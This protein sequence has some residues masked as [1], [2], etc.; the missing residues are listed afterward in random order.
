MKHGQKLQVVTFLYLVI[1]LNLVAAK[2]GCSFDVEK[3]KPTSA[4]EK[5]SKR[6]VIERHSITFENDWAVKIDSKI[7]GGTELTLWTQ[8]EKLK[9][10]AVLKNALLTFDDENDLFVCDVKKEKPFINISG[11]E[12]IF[13]V[14]NGKN[15]IFI[16]DKKGN[17]DELKIKFI[18]EMPEKEHAEEK[19]PCML[20]GLSCKWFQGKYVLWN[21]A[22]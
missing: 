21:Y 16:K 7:I 5:P 2:P 3:T 4:K 18:K 8:G 10:G 12:K 20:L 17:W 19:Y 13:K 6:D 1:A 11:T 14:K 9:S 22:E 15:K